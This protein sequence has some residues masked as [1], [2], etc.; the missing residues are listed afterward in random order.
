MNYKNKIMKRANVMDTPSDEVLFKKS[1]DEIVP[2][3][4]HVEPFQKEQYKKMFF[5]GLE[6]GR[7][8]STS[9]WVSEEA[10]KMYGNPPPK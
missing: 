4:I 8:N 10:R 2:I 3:Q 1:F 6:L 9:G 5:K 7:K